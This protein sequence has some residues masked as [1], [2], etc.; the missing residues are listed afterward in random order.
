MHPRPTAE[1]PHRVAHLRIDERVDDHRRVA[2]RARDGALEIGDRLAARM[3]HL[4]ELLFRK[5]RLQRLDESGSS[6]AGRV[7]DDMELNGHAVR[8]IGSYSWGM[9]ESRFAAQLITG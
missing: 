5:L 7:G 3:A 6:L 2:A 8:L 1:A 9:E 4:L